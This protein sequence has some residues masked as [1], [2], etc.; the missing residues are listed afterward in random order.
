[1]RAY[2]TNVTLP[3]EEVEVEAGWEALSRPQKPLRLDRQR[4]TLGESGQQD[5]SC[6]KKNGLAGRVLR[7]K[8][9]R[10]PQMQKCLGYGPWYDTSQLSWVVWVTVS[11]FPAT[12]AFCCLTTRRDGSWVA[13][14]SRLQDT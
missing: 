4:G 9:P 13:F 5:L 14:Q 1:M 3:W 6:Q 8:W 12:F 11:W 2:R 7:D 10:A